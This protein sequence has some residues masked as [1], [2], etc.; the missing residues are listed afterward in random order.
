MSNENTLKCPNCGQPIDIDEVLYHQLHEKAAKEFEEASREQ[1]KVL[2]ERAAELEGQK[3]NLEEEKEKVEELIRD[4][5]KTK[6]R[7]ER[8][9][10]EKELRV[11]I[12]EEKSDQIKTLEEEVKEKSSQLKELNKF[13]AQVQKL[14]REKDEMKDVLEAEAEQKLTEAIKEERA[15]IKKAEE[16]KVELKLVEKDNLI[17][18]LTENLKEAQRRAEQGSM[19]SQGEAQELAIEEFLRESF[20]LDTIGEIKK[21]ARGADCLQT[22]NTRVKQNCGTIYYESKRTKTFSLGWIEKFRNDM[23]EKGANIGV[24]V[25]DAM[26]SD[27]DR[28]GQK[29]GVWICTYSEFKGLCFVLRESIIQI[30][31]AVAT[32]ENKGD[33]MVMLYDF[34]TSNEFKLQVEGIVEGFTQMKEDLEKE[35]R[36]I[37]GHWKRREKQIEKVVL[38][39]NFM[40]NSIK[41]IAGS[42]V[43]SIKQL[44]MDED[45]SLALDEGT[46]QE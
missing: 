31:N 27:M 5:V 14:E 33:K 3:K 42:A 4:G 6:L 15:K 46:D 38:N 10:L 7:S 21:G 36:S 45:D 11:Q 43:S 19:Q 16:E 37:Q 2:R 25:T 24:I 26:P 41:G 34:L 28:M 12:Q 8:Q 35:K 9:T 13:K 23:R 29:E 20:P 40:Y 32:Q 39:T 30:N 22:V 44:E 1:E 17:Q 18:Q